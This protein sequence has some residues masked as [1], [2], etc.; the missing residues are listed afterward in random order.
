MSEEETK[1]AVLA[2]KVVDIERRVG[3]ME[4]TSQVLVLLVLTTVIGT[5]LKFIGLG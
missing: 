4:K 3:N 2:Q 1:L 5:V